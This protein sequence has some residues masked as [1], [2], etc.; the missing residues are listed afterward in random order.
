MG[1]LLEV[2]AISLLWVIVPRP[3][4]TIRK[5]KKKKKIVGCCIGGVRVD[6]SNYV[7]SFLI[8]KTKQDLLFRKVEN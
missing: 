8:E 3:E 1:I 6:D 7:F 4:K 2:I 5:T